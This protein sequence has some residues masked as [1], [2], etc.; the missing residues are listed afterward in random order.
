M[1][2]NIANTE[3]VHQFTCY[4]FNVF[5]LIQILLVNKTIPGFPAQGVQNLELLTVNLFFFQPGEE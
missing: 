2:K 1:F 3:K 4:K 5:T